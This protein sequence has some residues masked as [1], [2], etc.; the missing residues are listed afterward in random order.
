[1]INLPDCLVWMDL[2]FSGL[3]PDGGDVI[4][5]IATLITNSDLEIIAEGP[6][7]A[8]HQSEEVLT[9]MDEWNTKHHTASGLVDRVRKSTVSHEDADSII[10]NFILE[11][12]PE[13]S[14]PLCGNSIHQ[15]RRFL[16]RYMPQVTKS[17]HYRNIDVS[18]IKELAMRWTPDIQPYKKKKA[19][20]ALDDIHE[21]IEELRYFR[22][23]WRLDPR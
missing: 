12:C 8:I 7:F 15:D 14:S 2:E 5:E 23:A 17:L 6:A 13:G 22:K 20:L 9:S 18:T 1:M 11:H 21:S 19:H 3:D 16:Y 4:L 10:A